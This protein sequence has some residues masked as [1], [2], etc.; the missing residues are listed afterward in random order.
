MGLGESK[1]RGKLR[2]KR[3]ELIAALDGRFDDHHAELARMLLAQIDA[4]SAQ[5]NTL[6]SRIENLIAEFAR[7]RRRQPRRRRY[8]QRCAH[9]G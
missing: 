4:L 9:S 2:A 1:A 8:R 3:S 7:S 5:I 6:T